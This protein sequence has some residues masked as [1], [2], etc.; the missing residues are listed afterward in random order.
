MISS[1]N[2]TKSSSQN[3]KET[4]KDVKYF[5]KDSNYF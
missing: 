5:N 2:T 1:I 4:L 3:C